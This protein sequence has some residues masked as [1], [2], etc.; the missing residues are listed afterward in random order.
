M[1]CVNFPPFEDFY[2]VVTFIM[3]VITILPRTQQRLCQNNEGTLVSK[4]D[5]QDFQEINHKINLRSSQ[6][7]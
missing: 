6:S 1:K 4:Q 7:R 5:L 3:W 2:H